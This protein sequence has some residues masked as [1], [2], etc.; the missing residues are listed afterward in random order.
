MY[1]DDELLCAFC[2][3]NHPESQFS[4]KVLEADICKECEAEYYVTRVEQIKIQPS[5]AIEYVK[6]WFGL[7]SVQI[8][9][10][11]SQYLLL[12]AIEY[13]EVKAQY[14]YRIHLNPDQFGS[15]AIERLSKEDQNNDWTWCDCIP[16]EA[17]ISSIAN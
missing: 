3:Q 7:K 10:V 12:S 13:G 9:E 2:M 14:N 11:G 8:L 6:D 1:S 16:R 4:S 15:Y 5:R 17:I